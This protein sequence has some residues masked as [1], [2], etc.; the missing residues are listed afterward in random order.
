MLDRML[1]DVPYPKPVYETKVDLV[2]QHIF[3]SYFG[4]G[5]SL[6]VAGGSN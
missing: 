2:Y 6:Y 1:P 4:A 3:E 5:Q